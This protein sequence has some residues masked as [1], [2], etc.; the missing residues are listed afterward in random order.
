MTAPPVFPDPLAD[1]C[2]GDLLGDTQSHWLITG[3]TN[4]GKSSFL[5]ALERRWVCRGEVGSIGGLLVL[6][7]F[8]S[9]Q[10][11]GYLGVDLLRGVSFP[12]AVRGVNAHPAPEDTIVGNW[13]LRG[14]GMRCASDAIRHAA[15]VGSRLIAVDEF[16][17][18]ESGG[19]GLR[20]AIDEAARGGPRLLIVVRS[21]MVDEVSTLYA[22]ARV[23]HR[24]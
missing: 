5:R 8:E 12:L 10:K 23:L 3:P 4:S 6:G 20:D 16:G 19:G 22:P 18:L 11:T 1:A 13:L 7:E 24:L 14:A 15:A 21:T 2:I 17:P 9:G